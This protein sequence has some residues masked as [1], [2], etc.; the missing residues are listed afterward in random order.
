MKRDECPYEID[1]EVSLFEWGMERYPI[2]LKAVS[3]RLNI[4]NNGV[5]GDIVAKVTGGEFD[6]AFL[7]YTLRPDTQDSNRVITTCDSDENGEIKIYATM[8]EAMKPYGLK[9]GYNPFVA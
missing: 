6:G 1:R 8:R 5:C 4:T 7:H 9:R 3:F 2:K